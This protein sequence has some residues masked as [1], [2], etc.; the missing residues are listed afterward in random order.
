VIVVSNTSPII[1]LAWVGQLG[2]LKKLYGQ[3]LVPEAVY[4]EVVVAGA[5]K[6]GAREVDT[7]PSFV[8]SALADNALAKAL[9]SELD[10]GEAEA[11]A[12]AVERNA[13]L[14]L[15]DERR[16]RTVAERYSLPMMGD[17]SVF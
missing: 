10:P 13:D 11:I 6:P 14:V 1:N 15:L 3:V 16:A 9:L 4:H 2:L 17:F 12:L 8:R 5:G 7:D